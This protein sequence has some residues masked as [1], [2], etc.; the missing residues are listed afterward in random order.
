MDFRLPLLEFFGAGSNACWFLRNCCWTIF[1]HL[2]FVVA[3][4]EE[5]RVS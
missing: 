2:Q 5:K 1:Q 4:R 3:E